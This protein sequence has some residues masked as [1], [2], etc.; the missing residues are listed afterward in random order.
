MTSAEFAAIKKRTA[1]E[2]KVLRREEKSLT[3]TVYQVKSDYVQARLRNVQVKL[4]MIKDL[5]KHST[6]LN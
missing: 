5:E 4:D 6:T 3:N 1:T 2:E